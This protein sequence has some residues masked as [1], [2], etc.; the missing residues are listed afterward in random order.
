M[1]NKQVRLVF[2]DTNGAVK[3]K[4]IPATE[5]SEGKKFGMPRSVL[6]QDIEGEESHLVE[7][8]TPESGDT[9]MFLVPDQSTHGPAP[10]NDDMDQVAVDLL[11][12]NDKPFPQAPR[13][14]LKKV[15]ESVSAMGYEAKVAS[16]LEFYITKPNGGLFDNRELEQPY[17][18]INALDKLGGVLNQL[19]DGA[20]AVGLKPEAVLSESG[21]GQM[22]INVSPDE[23]LAMADR[24][25]FF[26]QMVREVT[27]RAGNK[28][29]F[30][31]KPFAEHSGSGYHLHLSLWKDGKNAF[32]EDPELLEAF[33][34]GVVTFAH[35]TYAL[36]A[37]NPNSYRRVS[38]SHGYVPDRPTWGENDRRVAFRFVGA[39]E[40]RRL[41]NRIAGSDANPYLLIAATLAAGI[42][43]VKDQLNFESAVVKQASQ[44]PFVD[45][46]PEAVNDLAGSEFAAEA[47][48][49]EFIAAFS[50]IKHVEWNKFQAQITHWEHDTYGSQV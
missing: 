8:F 2:A 42:K 4:L 21:P 29:T 23:P 17:G 19:V 3:G 45:S 47:F 38:L 35:D 49:P 28:A 12:E 37:P 13:T 34:A 22:E 24:T 16:E 25:L 14:V 10:G 31:A 5:Y 27:R 43:G 11:D 33:S 41:E 39:G 9:D 26:K 30:L 48:S 18:D 1:A 20:A 50:A 32:A 7:G 6:I 40:Q 36:Y 44:V 15:L 46:L